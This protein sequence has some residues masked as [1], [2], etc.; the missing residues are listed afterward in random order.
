MDYI[1]SKKSNCKNCYKCIRNCPVKSI[2]LSDGQAQIVENECILCGQCYVVC[3]Q[4]AKFVRDDV[5]KAFG[6]IA[7]GAK[8]I[9]SLAPS[10]TAAFDVNIGGMRAALKRLGFFDVEETAIGATIVKK[11][12]ERILVEG[13]RKIL[14]SSCCHSANV[15][16]QKYFPQVLP[17]LAAV[18]S[19]MVAHCQDI[20]LRYPDAKTVF[21]GPCISKKA[22]AEK[23]PGAVDVV[24]TFEELSGLFLSKG[25][26]P[27]NA[28]D[29]N[30]LQ[31][32]ARLFPTVG[33]II[34][35]MDTDRISGYEFIGVDG[36]DACM[37]VFNDIESGNLDVGNCFIEVSA[38]KGSCIGGPVIGKS[39]APLRDYMKIKQVAGKQDFVITDSEKNTLHRVHPFIGL[40]R[41]NPGSKNI[42]D[43]MRQMG[44]TSKE[45]ELNC[46]T[47]GYNTCREKAIA[48]YQGK[49]EVSMC[50][51]FIKERAESF[52]DNIIKITPN[53]IIV[54]NDDL[55]LQQINEAALNMFGIRNSKDILGEQ[56]S[57]ILEVEDFLQVRETGRM[58]Y[59]KHM[60]LAE[61]QKYVGETIVYDKDY[62]LFI[63]I[64]RDV[65]D[66]E[67]ERKKKE[68]LSRQTVEIADQVTEK[69]MRVVQEIA[70]LLG[71]TTAETKIALTKLK[72][73][74]KYE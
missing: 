10:F 51:P 43:I 67:T 60:Y 9:V 55:E 66:I 73:S 68:R 12:Y 33:G 17:H 28:V 53:G 57:R 69:Q 50:L 71:E 34:N 14:I 61:Y 8:V 56:L 19:P 44:K 47:C 18:V 64:I 40:S 49:A 25:I 20:K 31:T 26:E 42:E 27:E 37:D 30:N 21:I 41:T 46:G 24:L 58:I 74:L 36:V 11:E 52:S 13:E 3:P 62:H 1:Q 16:I 5:D 23:Y 59:D 7:S 63:C 72:E 39:Y 29:E 54:A 48:V 4:Q 15:L 6:L 22:E 2:K 65:T 35:T 38:C 32:R 45:H 70:Y